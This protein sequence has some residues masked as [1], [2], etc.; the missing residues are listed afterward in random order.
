M[1]GV[2]CVPIAYLRA[3]ARERQLVAERC[4]SGSPLYVI[5]RIPADGLHLFGL[6]GRDAPCLFT[7]AP[8]DG[9]FNPTT[10]RGL[11]DA[12]Q[13]MILKRV[14]AALASPLRRIDIADSG[15]Y[16]SGHWIPEGSHSRSTASGR[17]QPEGGQSDRS[18]SSPPAAPIRWR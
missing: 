15:A 14:P 6:L 7:F 4:R 1:G 18:A 8:C 9:A 11:C 5:R 13:K 17:V 2:A 16:D 12:A 3:V 10:Y